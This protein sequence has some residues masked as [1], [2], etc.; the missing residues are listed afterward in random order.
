MAVAAPG[1][2]AQQESMLISCGAG[3]KG[4]ECN[5]AFFLS[6]WLVPRESGE[7]VCRFAAERSRMH[8]QSASSATTPGD[9]Q[10]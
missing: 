6:S 7:K 5:F 2:R 3:Q 1:Q 10:P 4:A 8:L 9:N